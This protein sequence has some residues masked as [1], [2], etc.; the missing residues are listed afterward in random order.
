[1]SKPPDPQKPSPDGLKHEDRHLVGRD[2]RDMSNEEFSRL[3]HKKMNPM[4]VIR[5][6]CLDCCVGQPAEVRKC[7]AVDCALWPYRM[8][9]N[10]FYGWG[11][12]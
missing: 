2:P 4:K 12:P 10:P 1:M 6:K 9:T 5:A 8:G 11:R 7:T 3:K